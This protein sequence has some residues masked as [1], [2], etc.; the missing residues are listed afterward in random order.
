MKPIGVEA[1][2]RWNHPIRGFI[3]PND[4]IPIIEETKLIHKLT[5]WVLEQALLQV[6]VF[7][8]HG[9]DVPISINVSTSNLVQP[10]FYENTL[11]IIK[12]HD[13]KPEMIQLEITEHVL[14]K[15]PELCRSVLAQFSSKGIE[16]SVD[17]FGTGYS[18]LAYLDTFD[19]SV[20]KLDRRFINKCTTESSTLQ[21][22]TSTIQLARNLG[23]KVVAEGIETKEQLD[24]INSLNCCFAQGFYFAKPMSSEAIISWYQE[25]TKAA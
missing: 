21:I 22:V 19:I 6:K 1:L 9:L 8:S 12:S 10:N 3:P 23:Y 17:D 5:N 15:N 13:V 16:M 2:I 14:M 4:F 20:V 25:Q 24:I 18:S 11:D 7:K